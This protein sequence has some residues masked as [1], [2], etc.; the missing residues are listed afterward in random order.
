MRI[1]LSAI[2]LVASIK[3]IVSTITRVDIVS[4]STVKQEAILVI[5]SLDISR[6]TTA[7]ILIAR[8]SIVFSINY[9][10]SYI[11]GKV[12]GKVVVSS[13]KSNLRVKIL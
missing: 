4:I 7:V 1:L 6:E 12:Y 11:Y 8:V 2:A 13:A 9:T 5:L 10:L 3:V